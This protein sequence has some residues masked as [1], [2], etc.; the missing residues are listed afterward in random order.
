MFAPAFTQ[1][2]VSGRFWHAGSPQELT[3]IP[4]GMFGCPSGPV[5][6]HAQH[7]GV[8]VGVGV[9][10]GVKVGVGVGHLGSV[11]SGGQGSHSGLSITCIPVTACFLTKA[12]VGALYGFGTL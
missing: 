2:G 9:T 1:P 12:P 7:T 5:P 6:E 8:V 11:E 10:V 4:V 3:I